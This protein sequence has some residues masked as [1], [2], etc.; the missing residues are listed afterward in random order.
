MSEI[1]AW[2]DTRGSPTQAAESRRLLDEGEAPALLSQAL[3]P[4]NALIRLASGPPRD[5]I[6]EFVA[7]VTY[8]ETVD[9]A[10]LAA[11]IYQREELSS[12]A[13]VDGVA[14][15]HTPRWE[16]RPP[17]RSPLVA[18]GRLSRPVDFGA[19]DGTLTD[20]LFLLLAPD[21]RTHLTLLA[22]AARLCRDPGLVTGLRSAHT[23]HE[24]IDLIRASER[25]VFRPDPKAGS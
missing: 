7:A 22:K 24:V 1:D 20:L 13:T 14:F 12:T 9:G 5:V 15:L 16:A 6:R 21:A 17:I 8:P 10:A 18:V 2:L 11:R 4:E 3:L 23:P 25:A 19:I